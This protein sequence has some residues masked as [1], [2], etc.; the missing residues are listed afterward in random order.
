M[1]NR[2]PQFL[3]NSRYLLPAN[4]HCTGAEHQRRCSHPFLPGFLLTRSLV[5]YWGTLGVLCLL[6]PFTAVELP[7]QIIVGGITPDPSAEL[8]VQSTTRGLLPPRMTTAQ[9]AAIASP[10]TGLLV[11]NTTLNCIEMNIGTPAAPLWSCLTIANTASAPSSTP[12]VCRSTALTPITHTTTRATGIGTATGLPTGVTATWA[13]NTITI[14]GTPTVAGTYNYS[15]PLTGGLGSAQA[16]GTITVAFN[17]VSAATSVRVLPINTALT[18]ITHTTTVATGIGTPTGLPAG[19]TASWASN[20]I[21]ISGTPTV[22][23]TFNYTIPLTGGCGSV[24]ATGTI[25]VEPADCGAFIAAGVWKTFKCHNLGAV[26]TADPFTPS[27]QLNGNY[28]QWGRS[29]VAASAPTGNASSQ[30]NAGAISGWSTVAAPDGAW[31]ETSR[32]VNDP[33]P[34]GFRVPTRAEWQAVLSTTLNPRTAIG[35]FA[36]GATNYTQGLRVGTVGSS[37]GLFLPA[38]GERRNTDGVLLDR[39]NFCS[40]WSSTG[41][42]SGSSPLAFLMG[43]SPNV[44]IGTPDDSRLTGRSVRC[45]SL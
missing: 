8:D 16:T 34:V 26:S 1:K 3:Q 21:T 23:G 10:A 27:W 39:G 19:V 25:V 22:S 24:N 36:N 43:F 4:I 12:T 13:S 41:F 20:T 33:C 29:A 2:I 44:L 14:S 11:F 37:S 28:Y 40:Y 18:P 15:I 17:T 35:T 31:S 42:V 45:I 32:T 6:F 9:R 30:A 5:K 38:A 7:A